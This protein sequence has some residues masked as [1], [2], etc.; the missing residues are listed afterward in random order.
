MH[1]NRIRRSLSKVVYQHVVGI[2]DVRLAIQKVFAIRRDGQTSK[3][4]SRFLQAV[5]TSRLAGCEVQEF[6]SPWSMR[7]K[8]YRP[9]WLFAV[10]YKIDPS[11]GQC[12]VVPGHRLI[13]DMSLLTTT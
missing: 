5:D 7:A 9:F 8:C 1:T 2:V 11:S 13:Q 10:V 4:R 6:D 12:P 3:I